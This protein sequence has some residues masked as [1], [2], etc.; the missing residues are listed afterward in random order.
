MK[1]RRT[2]TALNVEGFR[3]RDGEDEEDGGGN[4]GS[5]EGSSDD[6]ASG[7]TKQLIFKGPWVPRDIWLGKKEGDEYK[8]DQR[9][10]LVGLPF[11]KGKKILTH[12][13]LGR[14]LSS[15]WSACA[16]CHPFPLPPTPSPRPP[17]E[18]TRTTALLPSSAVF[19]HNTDRLKGRA[20]LR[21]ASFSAQ[22]R[23]EATA[24]GLQPSSLTHESWVPPRYPTCARAR[25][26]GKR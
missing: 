4:Q 25:L 9:G 18:H 2:L 22:L 24:V 19:P 15:A 21:G 16:R 6:T 5:A 23:Q 11:W 1:A 7:I 26:L 14:S 20:T 3:C 10:P 13:S 17:P 8:Y 12:S